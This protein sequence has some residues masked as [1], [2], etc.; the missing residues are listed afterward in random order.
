[1]FD[2]KSGDVGERLHLGGLGIA[3]QRAG[4]GQCRF[5]PGD[6]ETG[7]IAAAEVLCQGVACA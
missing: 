1:V 3:K 7:Q 4:G 2:A 6:S 5:F